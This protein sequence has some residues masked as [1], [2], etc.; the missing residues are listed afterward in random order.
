M[1]KSNCRLTDTGRNFS[2]S[3]FIEVTETASMLSF[4][5][6]RQGH[7]Y[8]A[9]KVDFPDNALPGQHTIQFKLVD[10]KRK[11]YT[12]TIKIDVQPSS[13]HGGAA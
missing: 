3:Q 8:Y 9:V 1:G 7:G 5:V 12:Q 11:S 10:R 13:K 6:A 2:G 4:P